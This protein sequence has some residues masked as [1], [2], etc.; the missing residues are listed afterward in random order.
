MRDG[1]IPQITFSDAMSVWSYVKSIPM[2]IGVL[3]AVKLLIP[4]RTR[5]QIRGWS[6]AM[7]S[8]YYAVDLALLKLNKLSPNFMIHDYQ[9][10]RIP[11]CT[12]LAIGYFF[13]FFPR[14]SKTKAS[15]DL[16]KNSTVTILEELHSKIQ[17]IDE[18]IMWEAE[19]RRRE[20]DRLIWQLAL[21][22]GLYNSLSS[23]TPIIKNRNTS[24][25]LVT[26][27]D[28]LDSCG[29]ERAQWETFKINDVEHS[30]IPGDDTSRPV[31]LFYPASTTRKRERN[32]ETENDMEVTPNK[33][34]KI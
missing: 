25:S 29:V 9:Y 10:L 3:F 27:C 23:M 13:Y 19:C 21:N 26:P 28:A 14:R 4:Y 6:V 32:E 33:L 11:L 31:N 1:I 16:D 24:I 8:T 34:A 17:K 18:K 22:Q 7:V 20:N 15:N 5:I 30:I 2:V 12:C